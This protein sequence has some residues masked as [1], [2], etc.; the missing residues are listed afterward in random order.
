MDVFDQNVWPKMD[1]VCFWYIDCVWGHPTRPQLVAMGDHHDVC[2]C[3]EELE[4]NT[5]EGEANIISAKP[6]LSTVSG[7]ITKCFA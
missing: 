3:R 2:M 4:Y 5:K 7:R 6:L 1:P